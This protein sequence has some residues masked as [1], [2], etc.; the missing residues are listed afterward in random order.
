MSSALDA[1][2]HIVSS[3]AAIIAELQRLAQLTPHPIF[4]HYP[5]ARYFKNPDK[6]ESTLSSN[7]MFDDELPEDAVKIS[8]RFYALWDGIARYHEDLCAWIQQLK[9]GFYIQDTL[10]GISRHPVGRALLAEAIAQLGWALL[11]M[12]E[13]VPGLRREQMLVAYARH[14]GIASLERLSVVVRV[15]RDTGYHRGTPAPAEYPAPLFARLAVPT[16]VVAIVLDRLRGDD[17]YDALRLWPN[18]EHRSVALSGQAPLVYTVLW[19]APE[20]MATDTV[21]MRELVDKHFSD[22][23]VVPVYLGTLHD[24]TMYWKPFK[25]AMSALDG[26]A[27]GSIK[28]V[29]AVAATHAARL[30]TA[31]ADVARLLTDGAVTFDSLT[32]SWAEVMDVLRNAN[33]SMRWA[34]L[35]S[36]GQNTKVTDAVNSHLGVNT[37]Q[38]LELLLK[39]AALETRVKD[40]V[41]ALG[42]T[43]G[44][45]WLQLRAEAAENLEALSAWFTGEHK[46]AKGAKDEQLS[47]W[48]ASLSERVAGLDVANAVTAGRQVQG[49]LNGLKDV[50]QY[51]AVDGSHQ[52]KQFLADTSDVL[53]AMIQVMN[54][55]LTARADVDMISDL[56]YAWRVIQQFVPAMHARVQADP[57]AVHDLR[58]LFIKLSSVLDEP[59]QRVMQAGSEDA[60]SVAE[61][62]S[63]QLVSFLRVVMSVVPRAVFATLSGIIELLQ[64][65]LPQLPA[66]LAAAALGQAAALEARQTLTTASH[67]IARFTDGVMSMGETLLGVVAVD[68]RDLLRDG[69]RAHLVSTLT[70]TCDE[71]LHFNL[72]KVKRRDMPD[73]V[74]AV[75]IQLQRGMQAS[76]AALEYAQD[77]VAM[78][79]LAVWSRQTA[80]VM[81]LYT[82]LEC[83]SYTRH[84]IRPEDSAWQSDAAPIPIRMTDPVPVKPAVRAAL[85]WLPSPTT[86]LGRAVEACIEMT[87]P[88]YAIYSPGGGGWFTREGAEVAG[89][90]MFGKL[91]GAMSVPGAGGLDRVLSFQLSALLHRIAKACA[92]L[93]LGGL[94]SELGP[95]MA[96]PARARHAWAAFVKSNSK[97]LL[98]LAHVLTLVGQLQLLRKH[99]NADLAFSARVDCNLLLSATSALNRAVVS[100]VQAH[101][102]G[103][104][105][106]SGSAAVPAGAAGE[107]SEPTPELLPILAA[108]LERLGTVEPLQKV[109]IMLKEPVPNIGMAVF[110]TF[111]AAASQLQL[112]HDFGTAIPGSKCKMYLDGWPL[113]VGAAT[114]LKQVHPEAAQQTVARAGQWARCVFRD[115][116]RSPSPSSNCK[117][118]AALLPCSMASALSMAQGLEMPQAHIDAYIPMTLQSAVH[119]L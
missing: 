71:R 93:P 78:P 48:F 92:R 91:T 87:S 94:V 113:A 4:S 69:V 70:L 7:D 21:M 89:L 16:D 31:R 57:T 50:C 3:G 26:T 108:Q 40:I 114:L 8:G 17:V 80:R 96:A 35:H 77:F 45:R 1:V 105:A 58:A 83:N 104:A 55:P 109:Y 54:L 20:A 28:K 62:Y 13:Y 67:R 2:L 119:L 34:M 51:E 9:D 86:F 97:Y 95:A 74:V 73:T 98:E 24:L 110:A 111:L 100:D 107:D 25:A 75:L 63:K 23:W 29:R 84:S 53:K 61:F 27:A 64:A 56:A 6:W 52:V 14:Q 5:D 39:L 43:S 90:T 37:E 118:S 82:E 46:F 112:D 99:I 10:A 117:A 116:V 47:A 101:Y 30:S 115:M 79:G 42:A 41:S 103:V 36:R 59:L 32:D 49:I 38:L 65:R 12:D 15:V 19:F 68:P 11:L 66:K 22:N 102:S 72:A 44:E 88:P 76:R 81:A 18:P 33:F 60:P 106:A 85:A